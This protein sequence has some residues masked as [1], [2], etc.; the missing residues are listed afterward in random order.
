LQQPVRAER[1]GHRLVVMLSAVVIEPVHAER[2]L[3]EP[4][5]GQ[6]VQEDLVIGQVPHD[7]FLWPG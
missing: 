3:A 6:L 4:D 2:V 1:D 5:A 7:D